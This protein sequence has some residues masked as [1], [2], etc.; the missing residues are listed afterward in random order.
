M[1]STAVVPQAGLS[2][3]IEAVSGDTPPAS[4][5]GARDITVQLKG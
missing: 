2:A 4:P 1:T 3:V 5:D